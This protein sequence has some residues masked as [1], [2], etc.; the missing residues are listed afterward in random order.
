MKKSIQFISF[1][2]IA[3][4]PGIFGSFFTPGEWYLSLARPSF[5]PPG[6]LFGP[7]WTLLYIIIGI[8]GYLVWKN[9]NTTTRKNAFIIYGIQLL[10]NGIWSWI[11]FG[12][13]RIDFAL[14]VILVLWI[15]ILLNIIF[16]LKIRKLAGYLLIPYL[17]WVTF[18]S[19]LNWSIWSLN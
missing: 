19:I 3:F 18:A 14:I 12:L 5:T 8:S 2:L 7:V 6:W 17:F 4:L 10:L 16:F 13:H 11:F 1:I 15:T 9:E